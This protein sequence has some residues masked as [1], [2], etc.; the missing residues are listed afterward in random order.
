M[1]VSQVDP[2]GNVTSRRGVEPEKWFD[3]AIQ[4]VIDIEIVKRN[5]KWPFGR[6]TFSLELAA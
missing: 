6:V 1:L 3:P 5:Q 2:Q 4:G